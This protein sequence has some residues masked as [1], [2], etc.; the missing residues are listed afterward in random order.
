MLQIGFATIALLV[1]VRGVFHIVQSSNERT[2]RLT[3]VK[4]RGGYVQ[5]GVA[6]A[7]A[8]FAIG[9]SFIP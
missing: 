1:L 4:R 6:L 3:Q 8:A 2:L 9:M 7:F 5:I